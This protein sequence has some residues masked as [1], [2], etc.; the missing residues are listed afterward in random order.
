VK[1][2]RATV[3]GFALAVTLF[4]IYWML[5]T[6]LKPGSEVFA[7]PPQLLP[8]HWTLAAYG[9]IFVTRDIG[10]FVANSLIVSAGATIVSVVLASLAAYGF[11]RFRVRGAAAF[12][13]ALLFTK[14]L[15]E[16]LL[17]VPY[18]QLMSWLGLINTHW[19]LIIAYSSF[20]LP[21][22]LWMLIGFF[23]SIPGELDE[24]AM[25][26]GASRL[27]AFV[28]VILPMARQGLVAVGFF[29]FLA[30]WN[31]YLWALVLT[32][33]PDMFV[34]SVGVA[35]MVGEYRVQWDELMAAAVIGTIPAV[36]LFAVFNRYLVSAVTAGA[37]K[38]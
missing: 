31:S 7:S 19:A 22:A 4:P 36:L 17:V 28:R 34:I 12:I 27:Q 32:T 16:T 24:A 21:F 3:I 37:V 1:T 6:S 38:G 10:R 11:S 2:V 9:N 20:A 8:V 26:D 29:T 23:R 33:T 15:P 13:I 14:M 30:A 35:N 5:V 18:F 25:I